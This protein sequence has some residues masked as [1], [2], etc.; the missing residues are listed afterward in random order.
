[1]HIID[2][3]LSQAQRVLCVISPDYLALVEASPEW[4]VALQKDP[5]VVRPCKR[6]GM[7]G[8]LVAIDLSDCTDEELSVK[9]CCGNRHKRTI[10]C[11]DWSPK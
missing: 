3:A 1:M 6:E 2:T 7:L 4:K 9:A 5:V 8:I 10:C 11:P